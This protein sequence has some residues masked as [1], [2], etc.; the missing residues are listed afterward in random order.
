[1]KEKIEFD[2][3]T[4]EENK[5]IS[6]NCAGNCGNAGFER[7]SIFPDTAG[8]GKD[9]HRDHGCPTSMTFPSVTITLVFPSNSII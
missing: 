9:I 5:G 2:S 3:H 1:V 8:M 6:K 4:H 7:Y